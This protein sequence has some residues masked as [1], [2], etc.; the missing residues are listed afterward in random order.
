VSARVLKG[1]DD[2]DMIGRECSKVLVVCA[3]DGLAAAGEVIIS[4]INA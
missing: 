3:F 2:V 4:S 1:D